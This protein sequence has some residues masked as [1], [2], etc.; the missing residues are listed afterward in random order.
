M[1]QAEHNGGYQEPQAPIDAIGGP[2]LHETRSFIEDDAAPA[3]NPIAVLLRLLRGRWAL[4]IGLASAVGLTLAFLASLAASPL[5]ESEGLVRIIAREKKI[6]FA[7][8]DDSR[9]RLF[10]AFVDGEATYL[11]S[12]AV[13]DRAFTVFQEKRLEDGDDTS[14]FKGFSD[15]LEVKKLK[16][17]IRV[18]AKGKNPDKA[19]DSVNALLSAYSQMHEEQSGRRQNLRVAELETRIDE[20][21]ARRARLEADLL[22]IGE[23]YD[24]SSLARAH[25]TKVTLLE[26]IEGRLSEVNNSIAKMEASN[27]S[28]DADTGDM[29]IKRA[30]LLDR[31]MADMVFE[32]AKRAAELQQMSLRY[33]RDHPKVARLTAGLQ[34]ID[35]AIENRR[36][37]IAT[38]GKTGAITG[39]DGAAASQSLKELIALRDKLNGRRSELS[40]QARLLNSKLI[41]LA[42]I[43]AERT[44]IGSML[45]DTRAV[46][47]QVLLESRNSLPGT[48]EILSRGSLPLQ[49]ISNKKAAL[50]VAGLIMGGGAVCVIM[51]ALGFFSGTIRYSDD[52]KAAAK[53]LDPIVTTANPSDQKE[54]FSRFLAHLQF[55]PNWRRDRATLVAVNRFFDGGHASLLALAE[56]ASDLNL[57]VLLLVQTGQSTADI[58][59]P[60]QP[61]RRKGIDIAASPLASGSALAVKEAVPAL[62]AHAA[63]YDL[64]LLDTGR[65][66]ESAAAITLNHM[67][68]V[69]LILARPQIQKR[70]VH[71]FAA[72]QDSVTSVFVSALQ[73]DPGL[74][75]RA[76]IGIHADTPTLVHAS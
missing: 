74:E 23:E 20:L 30:T 52:L 18:S 25:L 51:L 48:A 55:S 75:D 27:D 32:R 37:L 50:M 53:D 62:K 8:R 7:D 5:Y 17:L 70:P 22:T 45:A 73:D 21:L 39:G 14:D 58:S 71:R 38:L 11:K 65:T 54:G 72:Q 19:Q 2:F 35:D 26:E 61:L 68:D 3:V 34:V 15:S 1:T 69:R 64:V 9:L 12:R 59:E 36:R 40:D 24:A 60:A 44:E 4:T 31:A 56:A 13:L 6:L 16:G 66:L 76:Q 41:Q 33:Q 47:D 28:L 49:P 67:A 42:A 29:E 63:N 10:D 57:R 43:N 46:L